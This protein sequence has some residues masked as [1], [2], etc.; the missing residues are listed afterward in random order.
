MYVIKRD[1]RKEP[2][3]FDKITARINKLSYGLNPRFCDPVS[4]R[5]ST[6]GQHWPP[7]GP[8]RRLMDAYGAH[9]G[10]GGPESGCWRLQ[11]RHNQRAGRARRRDRGVP[12]FHSSRLC[13]GEKAFDHL[14]VIGCQCGV[15]L[16]PA[17]T[18]STQLAAR[19]AVSNLHKNTLKS[20][21]ET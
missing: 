15:L 18:P 2:V 17:H 10:A 21:K 16:T 12:D 1:G 7:T 13:A 9:A 14:C 11:G 5:L 4:A 19:I 20:F 6:T 8:V 3:K